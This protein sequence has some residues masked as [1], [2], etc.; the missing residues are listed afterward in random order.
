MIT[1][2]NNQIFPFET[3]H[4]EPVAN[5]E[6]RLFDYG[7]DHSGLESLFDGPAF[8]GL[9]YGVHPNAYLLAHVTVDEAEI[10]SIGTAP[11]CQRQGLARFLCHHF[12][13]Q[14]MAEDKST[15]FLEVAADNDAALKLYDCVGFQQI[16]LRP[17]YYRRQYGRVDAIVMKLVCD[18]G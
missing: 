1:V 2:V 5:L 15:I 8:R 10:L 18:K 3:A 6:T 17:S 11:D 12:I 7:L 4:I 13:T 14:M 16:G 9:V